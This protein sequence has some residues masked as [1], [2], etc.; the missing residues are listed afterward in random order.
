MTAEQ[1]QTIDDQGIATRC[2]RSEIGRRQS[3]SNAGKAGSSQGVEFG[4]KGTRQSFA[5]ARLIRIH[6]LADLPLASGAQNDR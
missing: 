3:V 4:R 1:P 6:N 5:K 2:E